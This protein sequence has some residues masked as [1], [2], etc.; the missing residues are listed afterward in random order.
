MSG[1]TED[2]IPADVYLSFVRSLYG[3]RMTLRAGMSAHVV[4]YLLV[5][6]KV[7]DPVY[8]GFCIVVFAIWLFRSMTMTFS[9]RADLRGLDSQKIAHWE[10]CYI[11]GSGLVTLTLGTMTGYS[12]LVTQ[13]TF[14]QIAMT[15]ILLVAMVSV[16]GRNFGS[17]INVDIIC[18]AAFLP[19][20]ISM[21]LLGDTY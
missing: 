12:F 14:A 9:D 1:K 4:T 5:F 17:R 20:M 21:F 3:N 19:V 16:V 2:R 11:F 8:L 7:G 10:W 13:D 6:I 15:S 18:A